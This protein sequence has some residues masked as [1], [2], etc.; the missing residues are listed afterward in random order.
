VT[1]LAAVLALLAL[2]NAARAADEAAILAVEP[3]PLLSRFGFFTDM[4]SL[5]PAAGVVAYDLAT[6]LYSDGALKSRAV[7]VPPGKA[8]SWRDDEALA[9]P[10]GSALIKTFAF[11]AD[12]R[13]PERDLRRIETRVLLH[14]EDGWKAHAYVWRDDLSDAELKVAGKRLTVAFLDAD[15]GK[16]EFEY[17]VPNRNQ[18]KGCHDIAG[19]IAP[20]GPKARSL[21]YSGARKDGRSQLAHW[22]E[23]GIL[24]DVPD[25]TRVAVA[26]DAFD[27]ATSV[28][29]R[30]RAWLDVNCA[31]CHREAGPA[32]NSGLFLDRGETDPV[33]LGI[34]KRPV[35]AGRGAGD[36]E[37]DIVPG[38]AER[39]ILMLRVESAEP[40]IM[41]PELGRAL[42]DEKGA[43]L[44]RQWIASMR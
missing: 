26:V 9:F 17:A 7:Y 39:S 24:V 12:F 13:A 35:A 31:H 20:I 18:C 38:Q 16:V 6:P 32:S 34:G 4:P 10:V 33:K 44:I 11:P 27:P 1:R 37:F 3:P 14:Q 30:A 22:R 5:A 21:H 29:A 41:M 2:A 8:A 40:G 15:G 25:L 28:E 36:R 42:V 43:A 19:A 23:L